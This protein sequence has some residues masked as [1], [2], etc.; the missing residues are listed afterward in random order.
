MNSSARTVPAYSARWKQVLEAVGGLGKPVGKPV[1]VL[2]QKG[3]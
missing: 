3:L 2:K 1:E